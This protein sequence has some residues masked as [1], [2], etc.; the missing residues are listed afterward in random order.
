MPSK[1]QQGPGQ[2]PEPAFFSLLKKRGPDDRSIALFKTIIWDYYHASARPMPWR[3]TSDP[4]HIYVSE[5]ML[6]QTQ[7][8]RVRT[9]YPEFIAAFPDFHSLA[10]A[11]LEDILRVWQGM[12]YNRRAKLM[13][14]A[15]E[16]IVSEF[17]GVLP[18]DVST[19]NTLPGLGPATAASVAAFAYNAPVVFIETNIRRVF[20]HFFFQGREGVTDAEI[21]PLVRRALDWMNPREWYY[22]LMDYGAMLKRKVINPNLRS[23]AYKRQSAFE[24]SARQIRG[25]ILRILLDRGPT[26]HDALIVEVADEEGRTGAIIRVLVAEGL[27]GVSGDGMVYIAD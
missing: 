14:E 3:E 13:K 4:Y 17:D 6:Q 19:L 23:T 25:M 20:I 2:D 16:R 8:E 22:A 27:I 12:G 24:G 7:V 10:R 5:V 15:A 11:P 9:K 21:L 26:K 18:A 1:K